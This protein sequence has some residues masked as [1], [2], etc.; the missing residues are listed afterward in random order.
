[1]ERDHSPEEVPRAVD[2]IRRRIPE[3]SLDLIFGVPGQT[4]AAWD[5]DL[6]QA[7]ELQ[8]AH[9]STY[10]L[11]YERGTPLWKRQQQ[12]MIRALDEDAEL[13]LYAHAIDRLEAAGFEHYEISNF[14]LP[15]RRS[16][17]NQVYWA[18]DSHFGFGMGAAR[19]VNGRRELNTRDFF[20]SIPKA[21]AGESATV[22]SDTLFPEQ[23][24]RET[25]AMQLRR[26][27]GIDRAAFRQQTDFDLDLLAGEAI[28]RHV[29]LGLLADNG[30]R[31][32]LTRQGK[33]VADAVITALL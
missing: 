5:D 15:G 26:S 6:S 16:R 12:G 20:T 8:P 33:Y 25:M 30:E 18:N 32:Y 27:C 17:H 10:G 23:R 29:D 11:T 4:L 22:S 7:L 2:A 3:V 19:Y 9:V 24:A 31:V 13:A 21:L 1:L 14:A 28:A